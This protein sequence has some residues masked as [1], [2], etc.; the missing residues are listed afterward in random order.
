MNKS[1]FEYCVSIRTVGKAGEKYI[2]ELQ[3]LHRQTV[4]PKHIFVHLAEGFERPKEQVGM[5]EYIVTP[6]GL[7]HQRACSADGVDTEFLLVLDDDVYFPEDSV[8]KMYEALVENDA[9]CIAPDTFPN[10]EM[11]WKQKIVAFLANDVRPRK[12][13]GWAIKIERNGTFS[14]NNHPRKHGVYPTQSAAGPAYLVRTSVFKAIHYEDELYVDQFPPGTYGEDQLNFNKLHR[15]G[16]KVL[17]Q[18]DAGIIHLDAGTNNIKEK[19]YEK[20]YYRAMSQ[21]ITWYRSCYNLKGNSQWEKLM[22]VCA[23]GFRF[24]IGAFTRL[25]YSIIAR[26]PKFIVA[27]IKGNL[28]ARKYVHS[29]NY[30]HVPNFILS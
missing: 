1:K 14:Y 13:D 27:H 11:T 22:C 26:S 17:L 29:E 28:A 16:F 6:K 8:E 18:Y 21:Y 2:Q 5:E 24:A 15:N 7:V 3:S 10:H 25:G 12:D 9:D 20:L 23:Y 19:S 4:K 30:L